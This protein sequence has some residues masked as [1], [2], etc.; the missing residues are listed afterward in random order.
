MNPDLEVSPL[1]GNKSRIEVVAAVKR[2]IT[3]SDAADAKKWHPISD[4]IGRHDARPFDVLEL[5]FQRHD[6]PACSHDTERLCASV[7]AVSFRHD[8]T[9]LSRRTISCSAD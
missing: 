3:P 1:R 5:V 9:A 4:E 2:D 7:L 8:V 6:R